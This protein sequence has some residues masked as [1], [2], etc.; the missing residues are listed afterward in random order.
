M[1]KY[2]RGRG[3]LRRINPKADPTLVPADGRHLDLVGE[4]TEVETPGSAEQ[5]GSR[6]RYAPSLNVQAPPN[7]AGLTAQ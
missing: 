7:S 4:I 2:A 6:M 5:E 1:W 3:I